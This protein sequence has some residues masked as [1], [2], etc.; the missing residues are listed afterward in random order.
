MMRA[1]FLAILALLAAPQDES[2]PGTKPLTETGDLADKMMEGLHKYV[3][4]KLAESPAGRAAFW[5]RDPS[6]P[7]AY[8]RSVAPNRKRFL[9]IIGA[10]DLRL[11]AR[12]ERFGDDATPALAAS[13]PRFKAYQVRW[14]PSFLDDSTARPI[15]FV[16]FPLEAASCKQL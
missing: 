16:T 7:E 12:L 4:R 2:L 1:A 11:P 14:P 15:C 9:E 10:V 6:S 3:D 5:K 13:T 8:E